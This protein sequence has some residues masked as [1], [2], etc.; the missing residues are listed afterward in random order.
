MEKKQNKN[1]PAK[2]R[3]NNRYTAKVYD[4]IKFRVPKGEKARLKQYAAEH[5]YSL[6]GFIDHAVYLRIWWEE[7]HAIFDDA[8]EQALKKH[9]EQNNN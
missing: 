4:E 2:I 5:G 9:K 3:A 7:N 6:N 8:V 1:S